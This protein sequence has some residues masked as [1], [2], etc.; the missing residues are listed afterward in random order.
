MIEDGHLSSRRER[1][2]DARRTRIVDATYALTR[3]VG[4]AALS[5]KMIADRADV[6]PATVYNLFG[7]KGAVIAKVYE[8]DLLVFERR[9]AESPS[10]D[11][12]DA[13]FDA[14]TIACD[15]YRA[16]PRFYRAAM[17]TRD[18]GLDQE[19]VLST[20]RPRI[21]FWRK[22]AERAIAEGGLRPDASAERLGVLMIQISTGALAR[23]V[24]NLV[25]IDGMELETAYGLA[26][27]LLCFASDAA[28]PRLEA[29]LKAVDAA[30]S[31]L[32]A[33]PRYATDLAPT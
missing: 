25:T 23:W 28:R 22:L 3:E 2:K 9:V 7:T 6:S 15:L 26:A 11:A 10:G 4:M 21:A 30:L 13:I 33:Q 29:R 12:L 32:S 17:D 5:V 8:R 27:A 20:Y 14:V 1:G 24:S 19:M 16:D 18:A 31:A